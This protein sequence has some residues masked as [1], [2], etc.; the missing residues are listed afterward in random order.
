[1][2]TCDLAAGLALGVTKYD[3]LDDM[4]I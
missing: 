3:W 1:M 2:A 4:G